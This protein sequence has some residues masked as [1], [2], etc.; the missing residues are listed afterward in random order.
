[1]NIKI[2]FG[3][4][5]KNIRK[6]KNITQEKLAELA[7]VD[8]SYISDVERGIKNISLEKLNQLAIALELEVWELLKFEKGDE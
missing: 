6:A 8:R 1:M 2:K 5:L 7:N 3:E 4:H